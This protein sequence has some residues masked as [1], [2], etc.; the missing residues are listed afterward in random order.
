M[1][2]ILLFIIAACLVLLTIKFAGDTLKKVGSVLFL[3]GVVV[4]LCTL[5]VL[6]WVYHHDSLLLVIGLVIGRLILECNWNVAKRSRKYKLW[7]LISLS[8]SFACLFVGKYVHSL[9]LLVQLGGFLL[10][11]VVVAAGVATYENI[12]YNRDKLKKTNLAQTQGS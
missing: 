3:L 4:A 9:E 5:V 11:A 12:A 6:W 8:I 10:I 2:E 7:L 1:I